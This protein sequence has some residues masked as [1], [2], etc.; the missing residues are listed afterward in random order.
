VHQAVK[1]P[2]A[3][4]GPA[5]VGSWSL[6][7]G[8]LGTDATN[9]HPATVYDVAHGS[10]RGGC[11]VFNGKDSQLATTGPVVDTSASG[12]FTV[13]AWVYLTS[14]ASFATAVSQDGNAKSAFYL[15]Y[16][17]DDNRWALAGGGRALSSAPPALNTWTHLVGV[18]D[19]ATQQMTLYVDG[20]RQ[21]SVKET[22]PLASTGG[23]AIGR[24]KFDGK[25]AD[26]FT[27]RINDVEIFDQ[28][29]TASQISRL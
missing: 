8:A 28:A 14:A 6:K 24:A 20:V 13:S 26:F 21:S 17:K 12:S 4:A 27:G 25:Y 18:R 11:G 29:L 19:A 2:K 15:Q 23:L 1:A 7:S 9:A 10:A 22:A 16:D 5:P 3:P